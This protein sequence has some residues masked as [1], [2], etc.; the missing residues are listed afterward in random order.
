MLGFDKA[1]TAKLRGKGVVLTAEKRNNNIFLNCS[2]FRLAPRASESSLKHF[3]F[4]SLLG[5]KW[6]IKKN[7]W[8]DGW[9]KY[10][11]KLLG[12]QVPKWQNTQHLSLAL[13]T[14]DAHVHD[15]FG[16]DVNYE[17]YDV[18][19]E[20]LKIENWKKIDKNLHLH[21][22]NFGKNIKAISV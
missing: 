11:T 18:Y 21:F 8:Y 15:P 4:L 22:L 7:G 20:H 5:Q 19:E 12:A 13:D 9:K 16:M 17:I 10:F 2:L 1:V 3:F 14:L 6:K